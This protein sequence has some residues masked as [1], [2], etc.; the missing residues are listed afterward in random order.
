MAIKPPSSSSSSSR[1]SSSRVSTPRVSKPRV[2][3]PKVSTPRISPKPVSVPKTKTVTTPKRPSVTRAPETTVK[4][5][6]ANLTRAKGPEQQ[7]QISGQNTKSIPRQITRQAPNTPT[8]VDPAPQSNQAPAGPQRNQAPAGPQRNQGPAAPQTPAQ[9]QSNPVKPEGTDIKE[10]QLDL[11]KPISVRS[12]QTAIDAIANERGES[13]GINFHIEGSAK[14]YGPVEAGA[15]G[16]LGL[17]VAKS[18]TGGTSLSFNYEAAVKAGLDLGFMNIEGAAGLNGSVKAK[19]NNSADAAAWLTSSLH[20]INQKADGKLF[21]IEGSN[22]NYK[23]PTYVNEQGAFIQGKVNAEFGPFKVEGTARGQTTAQTFTTPDGKTYRGN[24]SSLQAGINGQMDF[25]KLKVN[26]SYDFNQF[27]QIGDP[28]NENNG[29]FRNHKV[30]FDVPLKE[31][32][33]MTPKE[34]N[35][36]VVGLMAMNTEGLSSLGQAGHQ[37]M[38]EGLVNNI[39]YIRQN[40]PKGGLNANIGI[41][42]EAQNVLENGKYNNQYQRMFLDLKGG[43][44]AE[45]DAKVAKGEVSLQ[46]SKSELLKEWVGTNTESYAQ[47]VYTRGLDPNGRNPDWD[48]FKQDNRG[49]LEQ[50]IKNRVAEDPNGPVARAYGGA[51][52]DRGIQALERDW[53]RDANLDKDLRRDAATLASYGKEFHFSGSEEQ[54][55][56][57]ILDK[58]KNKP[59]ELTKMVYYMETMGV[60]RNKLYGKTG[61]YFSNNDEHMMRRFRQVDDFLARMKRQN[62]TL[63]DYFR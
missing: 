37:K 29:T 32:T 55:A 24:E 8:T 30:S 59:H 47:Q 53:S 41:T 19:F 12:V 60:D 15:W 49:A 20:K 10:A 35:N 18:D 43:A 38:V 45:F 2:S 46:A 25:G 50:M 48:R 39:D 17:K 56:L 40:P 52:I 14:V 54:H 4:P 36:A 9:P 34:I 23:K 51:N 1:M 58:Y 26:G 16:D 7:P 44:K 57:R 11:T 21:N 61:G 33:K 63:D 3:T 6:P 31:L 22:F 5:G 62:K 27:T 13:G 42:Y 28:T